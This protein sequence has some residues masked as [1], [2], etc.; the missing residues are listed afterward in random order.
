MMGHATQH[1]RTRDAMSLD[2]TRRRGQRIKT[3]GIGGDVRGQIAGTGE[4][5]IMY[6]ALGTEPQ[7]QHPFNVYGDIASQP[8]ALRETF[9]HTDEM[10]AIAR[11]IAERDWS[12]IVGI[13]SGTSQF[14]AQVA[15][16]A[17]AWFAGIP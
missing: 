14:C 16:A 8:D 15:N 4:H 3:W 11:T 1:H 5:P 13:G 12:G 9:A 7:T 10:D 17:F 2:D 6:R